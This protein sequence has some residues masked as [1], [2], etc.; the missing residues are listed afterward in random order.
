MS[1]IGD[2]ENIADEA[3]V[4]QDLAVTLARGRDL[5]VADRQVV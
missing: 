5:L 4:C 1:E 2:W 3:E